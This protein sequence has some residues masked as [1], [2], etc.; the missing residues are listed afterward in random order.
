M[1]RRFSR[2]AVWLLAG[3]VAALAVAAGPNPPY[4]IG[5]EPSWAE[6]LALPEPEE[7]PTHQ[8]SN[9][10]HYLL[11]EEQLRVEPRETYGQFARKF[12]NETGVQNGSEIHIGVDPAYETLEL[13]KVEVLRDGV[14]QQRLDPAIISVLQR[15]ADMERFLLDGSYTVVVRLNDIRPG[16]IL[17]YSF[18]MRGANPVMAGHFYHNFSAGWSH[19]C[20][21]LRQR[22]LVPPGHPMVVKTHNTDLPAR[23]RDVEGGTLYEWEA[24]DLPATLVEDDVPF[25]QDVFPWVEMGDMDRWSQVVDWALP[26]YDF[27]QPLPPE[28]EEKLA[29]L[30]RLESAEEKILGAL[31]LVQD[32]IRYFGTETGE[33]SYRPR[34]P[35]VVYAQRLGDCKEK[36]LLL[37]TLLRRLGFPAWPVLVSSGWG[38]GVE[39]RLPSPVAFDHVIL[40]TRLDGRDFDLD[41]TRNHQRGPL[42]SLGIGEYGRGLVIRPGE[43]RLTAMEPSLES[44]PRSTVEEIVELP[45]PGSE[46][47][48]VFKVY[49]RMQGESA[50]SA[51]ERFATESREALQERYKQ[52]YAETY[53]SIEVAKPIRHADN[54]KENVFEFWEEY[55]IPD[56]WQPT[57]TAGQTLVSFYPHEVTSYLKKPALAGRR[58]P[59]S[60]PHPVDVSLRTVVRLPEEWTVTPTEFQEENPFFDL[61][62]TVTRDGPAGAVISSRF[63]SRADHVPSGKLKEYRTR[64]EKTLDAL[65]YEFTHTKP[66]A[67]TASPLLG[68]L[69]LWPM[70]VAGVAAFGVALAGAFAVG[71]WT[72][73]TPP[74]PRGAG[75]D[76]RLDGL[77]G[78]LLLVGLA[79]ILRPFLALAG[80]GSLLAPY[81]TNPQI[82]QFFTTPGGQFYSP[83]WQPIFLYE[84][85][86]NT[87]VL[88]FSLVL[89]VLFFTKRK[90]FPPVYI[91]VLAA[92]AVGGLV[93]VGLVSLVPEESF[94]ENVRSQGL[95]GAREAVQNVVTAL[96]W[97]PYLILSKRV[98]S[99]FRR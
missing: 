94:P 46:T 82:W 81:V 40:R 10:I 18:T 2:W 71:W 21:H 54:Q 29:A 53:P 15:E 57:K 5:P 68:W 99:T 20:A 25:W 50:E 61:R 64:A 87:M 58:H 66:A 28:L 74:T 19:P 72:W 65:G 62:Y 22:V 24:R 42:R 59:F 43:D 16:D 52:F 37:G 97:I 70:V 9:G 48:A 96:I 38:R 3:C 91:G 13:H 4:Q 33:H 49:T 89:L 84:I 73:T 80:L 30:A 39:N 31:R 14:W 23:M 35:S 32:D 17:R 34:A 8:I 76:I 55:H 85:A 41:P 83:L 7:V 78:W 51:R 69:R 12:L 75:Y 67:H 60:L 93:D 77:Q 92:V 11:S 6:P 90:T 79:V 44:V 95:P 56:I 26:L 88:V 98:Q 45:Q 36:T 63:R 47:P 1:N 27:D 86:L